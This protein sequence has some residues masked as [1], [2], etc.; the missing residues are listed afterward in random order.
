MVRIGD[1]RG[2]WC[3]NKKSYCAI[4]FCVVVMYLKGIRTLFVM[5]YYEYM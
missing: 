2:G 3:T 5:F 1:E 4:Y